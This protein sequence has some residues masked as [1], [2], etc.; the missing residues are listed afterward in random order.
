MTDPNYQPPVTSGGEGWFS[1]GRLNAQLVYCLYLVSFV[2]GITVIIGLIM[3]YVNRSKGDA[4][5]DTHYTYAIRTFWLGLLYSLLAVVAMFVLMGALGMLLML[6]V[7]IWGVIRCVIGLQKASA[8]QP[9][10]KPDTWWI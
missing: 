10:G 4:W 2:V 3:A 1:P 9:V 8:G 6:G 7:S 5:V